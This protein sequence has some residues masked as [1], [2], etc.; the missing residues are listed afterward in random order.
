MKVENGCRVVA[1][2]DPAHSF[3]PGVGAFVKINF[4]LN[5]IPVPGVSLEVAALGD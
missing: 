5:L 1:P 4:Q 2:V 3:Q